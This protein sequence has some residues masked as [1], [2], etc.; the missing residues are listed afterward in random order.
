M[1]TWTQTELDAIHARAKARVA[2]FR[3]GMDESE[4]M[5]AD[6]LDRIMD[7]GPDEVLRQRVMDY[8]N[9]KERERGNNSD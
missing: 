5:L 9:Q 7:S 2:E 1:G 8:V 4:R 6:Y 3:A